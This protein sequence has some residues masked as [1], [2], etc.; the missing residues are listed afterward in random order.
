[1][2]GLIDWSMDR[3]MDRWMEGRRDGGRECIHRI[4]RL[5]LARHREE[6]AA[7]STGAALR[8]WGNNSNSR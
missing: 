3:W 6:G 7:A 8:S 2:E 1:M 4:Q 5:L